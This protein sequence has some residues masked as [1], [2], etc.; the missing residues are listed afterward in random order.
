MDDWRTRPRQKRSPIWTLPLVELRALVAGS[1][2]F[3]EIL[4]A[5]DRPNAG[6]SYS[7]LLARIESE[8]IDVTHIARGVGVSGGSIAKPIEEYLV[9]NSPASRRNIKRRLIGEGLIENVC[10]ICECEPLWQ[11]QLLILVLDHINGINDDYRL[12]NLRLLC[13]NC[14][15]QQDT[16]AG[17][18]RRR[19]PALTRT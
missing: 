5:L 7:A 12:E 8:Q 1:S 15:S 14:N 18:N 17:R 11:G 3:A 6:S 10:S 19:L 2:T 9:E 16:F 13:P 4:R